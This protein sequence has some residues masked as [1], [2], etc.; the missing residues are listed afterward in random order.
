MK[1]KKGAALFTAAVMIF[2]AVPSTVM[3]QTRV[4]LKGENFEDIDGIPTENQV[5]DYMTLF[6][7]L[8]QNCHYMKDEG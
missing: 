6:L 8:L 3:G 5:K 2:G 4:I 1:L 7:H